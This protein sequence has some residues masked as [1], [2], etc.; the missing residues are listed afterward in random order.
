MT[1]KSS[2]VNADGEKSSSGGGESTPS[3][4]ETDWRSIYV[5]S[6]LFYVSMVQFTLYFSSI[7]PYLQVVR[8][9]LT[10]KNIISIKKFLKVKNY[11]KM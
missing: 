3:V 11:L 10:K 8:V 6:F 9:F 2:P 5:A 4:V 7:W 1:T